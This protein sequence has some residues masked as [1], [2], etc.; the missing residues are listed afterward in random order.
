MR[1]H[2]PLHTPLPTPLRVH[3]HVRSY[4]SHQL[5]TIPSPGCPTANTSRRPMHSTSGSRLRKSQSQ[6]QNNSQSH[7]SSGLHWLFRS[8][9]PRRAH[10]RN[11]FGLGEI[12]GVLAN[13]AETLRS[14]TESKRLLE[15]ARQE[16]QE[17]KE[18]AQLRV[19]HTFSRYP[20]FF[21][22]LAEMHILDKVLGGEPSF[23]VLF[24]SSSV[25]KTALLREVLSSGTYHVLHFDLRI[26]GF[27]DLPSLYTSLSQQM[28]QYFEEIG[29]QP[30]Y[31]EFEK[32]AWGFKHDRLNVERRTT[33][34]PQG[35]DVRNVRT[36][37][38]ARL[39]ELFQSSLLTYREFEP[40]KQEQEDGKASRQE[41]PPHNPGRIRARSF[42]HRGKGKEKA[43][44]HDPELA[45]RKS[46]EKTPPAK[47]IP[48]IFFDEAHRLPALIQSI[49]TMKCL[50]DSMLVLTKQDRLCHVIHATSDPFYQTWLRQLNVMQHC[51]IITIGDCSKA[52]TRMFFNEYI[53]P[54]VPRQLHAGID[55]E[56]LYEAFGG[57]LAHWH[58]YC[59]DFVNSGGTLDIKQSSHFLQA[60]ALLNL[61]L[62]HA[63]Q[64]STAVVSTSSNRDSQMNPKG[65]LQ[66]RV[67]SNSQALHPR[68]GPA[69]FKIYSPITNPQGPFTEQQ[70]PG[71]YTAAEFSAMDLLKPGVRNLAY[72]PLCRELGLRTVD[73][74]VKGRVLDLRWTECV[75]DE[76]LDERSDV[77]LRAASSPTAV[78]QESAAASRSRS[79]SR[80]DAASESE[81]DM[82]P[83]PEGDAEALYAHPQGR[84]DAYPEED[85]NAEVVGC[86][87][88][89]S[90]IM[91]F[92]MRD[93][94]GEY[95]EQRSVS[96]YMSLSDVDVEEY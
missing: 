17:S 82:E 40:V 26:A 1:L 57:K 81:H 39:M 73:G 8:N 24:G 61:H 13:P 38:V 66:G 58:D 42:F 12:I 35:S 49:E 76:H 87:L 75:T 21:P 48:I 29:K 31:E 37:D 18:R 77:L 14:L 67:V 46:R 89:V 11:F 95:E 74:M 94:V 5:H 23:T 7:S 69:G 16:I 60:H 25:G 90:P 52:E 79:R 10:K 72:F 93:V 64:A 47:K 22:R 32:E 4:L 20:G 3:E 33:D 85:V 54:R 55:F 68:L 65:Q 15:D 6:R 70:Q 36:S 44:S 62:V 30:G 9:I 51:K 27:A 78:D 80:L 45:E 83:V 41:P 2:T 50:L 92:A 63:S 43:E 59:T 86:K 88:V 56:R 53:L 34:T 19:K 91:R 71:Y 96:D 84:P 28:E